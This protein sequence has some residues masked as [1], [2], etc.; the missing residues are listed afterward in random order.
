MLLQS[1][2][3]IHMHMT[4]TK[5]SSRNMVVCSHDTNQDYGLH[6][7]PPSVISI[8]EA[9]MDTA[10]EAESAESNDGPSSTTPLIPSDDTFFA[11]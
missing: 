6:E 5:Q 4:S 9:I 8:T 11:E 2:V 3:P 7:Q 1:L 10:N